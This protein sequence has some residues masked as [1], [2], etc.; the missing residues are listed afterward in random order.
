VAIHWFVSEGLFVVFLDVK[1]VT[2]K[3]G[4]FL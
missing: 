2:T 4:F 1:L 3:F